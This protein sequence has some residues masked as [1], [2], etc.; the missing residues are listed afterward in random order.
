MLSDVAWQE[1]IMAMKSQESLLLG[2]QAEQRRVMR[3]QQG[4]HAF[5]LQS[6]RLILLHAAGMR[7]D[8][9]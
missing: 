8:H 4:A 9:A 5:E 1:N 7:P 6:S 2:A 3:L